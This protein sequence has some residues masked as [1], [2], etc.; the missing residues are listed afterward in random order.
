[1]NRKEL[2]KDKKLRVLYIE[3]NQD[4]TTGGSHIC[5]LDVIRS[6]DKSKVEPFVMFYETHRLINEFY[7]QNARV[8]VFDRPRA[9]ELGKISCFKIFSKVPWL[10]K[11]PQAAVN[12]LRTDVFAFF[13]FV[14][15]LLRHR[16]QIIHLNNT[17]FA[18]P[19]W[20][21]AAKLT[22]TKV[23]VHERTRLGWVPWLNKF[24]HRWVDF[25]FGVSN[26]TKDYLEESGVDVSRYATL[27]D[28]IDMEKF[29]AVRTCDR[30]AVRK[31][32]SVEPDQPLI[33]IVGNLQRWKGQMTVV[34]AV[35]KLVSGYPQ[36][37]CRLIGDS[38]NQTTDD[39]VY[40][41][42]LNETIS[43]LGLENNV[44]LTGHRP[45]VPDLLNALDI[46][47][48]A[49]LTPEPYGL[50][51]LEAMAMG[52][53]VIASNEGGPVEMIE[54]R[55]SGV[56]IEPGDP[57]CLAQAIDSL[58]ENPEKRRQMGEKAL[59]RVNTHFARLDIEA[60]EKVYADLTG[61]G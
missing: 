53:A 41:K 43:L 46:F 32:I 48:H 50:V 36:I 51:V 30:D 2:M 6:L 56:L 49:S 61:K 38:S 18:G 58:L 60:V 31:K 55:I 1:M 54:D 42:E 11:I 27:Y 5:L 59:E 52:K 57:E 16:I 7:D 45:D 28:R 4:G 25:I 14:F 9:I 35:E 21:V 39:V 40:F 17:V 22:A 19:F 15:F 10:L 33:G 44:T 20:T 3:E 23:V 34:K 24:H 37:Q 47:I 13:Y 26:S 29:S 12:I 8:F